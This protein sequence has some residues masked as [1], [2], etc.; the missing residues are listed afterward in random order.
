[1]TI[2]F[3]AQNQENVGELAYW[4]STTSTLL[5]LLQRTLKASNASNTG[6]HRSRATAVTLFSRLAWVR[7]LIQK[8]DM[9]LRTTVMNIVCN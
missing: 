3:Y 8:L 7:K 6:S 9:F 2:F 5:F 4:L 1:M